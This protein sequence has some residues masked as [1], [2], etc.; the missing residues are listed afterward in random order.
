MK[1]FFLIII[2]IFS[3]RIYFCQSIDNSI[4]QREIQLAS[5]LDSLRAADT[6]GKRLDCNFAFK[7]YLEET[8]KDPMA[9]T[10]AFSKLKTVGFLNSPDGMIRIVNWNVELSDRSHRYYC[11]ILMYDDSKEQIFTTELTDNQT[12][13]S[14]RTQEI[15][16]AENWYGALYYKIIPIEKGSKTVYTLLG[17][18]GNNESTNIKIID[19]LSFSQKKPKFGSPMFKVSKTE[20]LNRVFFE[21]SEKITMS[22]KFEPEYKRIVFDHLMP[23]SPNLE[24]LYSFYVP[25]FSYDAFVQEGNKWVLFEDVVAVNNL[26]DEKVI[27]YER[28]KKTGEL[29]ER[30]VKKKWINPQDDSAPISGIDHVAITPDMDINNPL[31]FSNEKTKKTKKEKTKKDNR[32]PNDMNATLGG[33]KNKKRRN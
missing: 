2:S 9:F 10:Y 18:D 32:D 4:L 23:E 33:K 26:D 17:W 6:D 5:L 30:K 7:S 31:A 14:E 27:A 22:L 28:N 3:P 25:D 8:L 24:G 21:H 1:Y 13:L 12:N 11:Y 19:V 16:D 15:L 29:E 20:T